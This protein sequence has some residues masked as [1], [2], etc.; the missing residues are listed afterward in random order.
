MFFSERARFILRRGILGCGL[1]LGLAIFGWLALNERAH[2]DP[3]H[4]LALHALLALFALTLLE[5]TV[6]AGW[7]IGALWWWLTRPPNDAQTG[8]PDERPRHG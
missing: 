8:S 4:P 7:V 5:W 2:P 3:A 6:G 1:P